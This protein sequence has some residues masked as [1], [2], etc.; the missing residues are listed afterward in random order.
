MGK[1]AK[2]VDERI[3]EY[4]VPSGEHLL[5]V[6]P[7]TS[8]QQTPI[9]M[10]PNFSTI[11]PHRWLKAKQLGLDYKDLGAIYKKCTRDQC[12]NPEHFEQ[13]KRP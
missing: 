10:L 9:L 6:G 2:P 8:A 12:V 3:K 4:T 13:G 5:W 1:K 7:T 11:G